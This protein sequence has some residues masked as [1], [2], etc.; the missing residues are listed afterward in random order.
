MYPFACVQ[1]A[2]VHAILY[3]FSVHRSTVLRSVDH[4]QKEMRTARGTLYN[5][6]LCIMYTP[7]I[8]FGS[9]QRHKGLPLTKTST[10]RIQI[11][12]LTPTKSIVLNL[13]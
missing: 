2:H 10:L 6:V 8:I 13:C 5:S 12:S 9:T 1:A 3:F 7:K 4:M 11:S